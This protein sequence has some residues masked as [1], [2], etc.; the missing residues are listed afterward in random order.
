M[1]LDF[2]LAEDLKVRS[3]TAAAIGDAP[4]HVAGA[5]RRLRGGA[6]PVD[7][8]SDL[9]SIGVIFYELLAGRRPFETRWPPDCLLLDRMI[10]ATPRAIPDIRRWNK[11]VTPAVESV[12]HHCL[13][14]EPQRRYQTP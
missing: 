2:N 6:S 8:R 11:T 13:E 7:A 14:P 10:E 5:P 12:I 4:L 1:L 9:Y 3:G